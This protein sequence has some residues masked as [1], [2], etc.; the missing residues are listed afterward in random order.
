[1]VLTI[2]IGNTDIVLGCL[3]S[4]ED[5]IF[6]ERLS[7][8]RSETVLEYA[9][10]IKN[11]LEIYHIDGCALEGAI[12][13]SVVPQLTKI[14][15]RAVR[16]VTGKLPLVV[17]PGVKNG[18]HIKVDNPA[19]VGSDLIVAAVA[20]KAAYT[21]P[22]V[23]I[24]MGTATTICVIDREGSYIG[25]MILPGVRGSLDSLVSRASQLSNISIEAPKRFIGKNTAECM[26]SGIVYGNAACLDGMVSR[27]EEDIQEK[28]TIIATGGLSNVVI[29]YCTHEII[30]DDALI[31]KGLILIYRMNEERKN[32][33]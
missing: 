10:G 2:D 28:A 24:D 16:K 32:R 14:I 15:S 20:A 3:N 17:G 22:L 33:V 7:T 31:L 26:K 25:G 4:G 5:I 27:I 13:S 29:P 23:I 30:R 18:L 6:V 12:V 21:P 8:D 19:Q 1:M 9:I 11:V